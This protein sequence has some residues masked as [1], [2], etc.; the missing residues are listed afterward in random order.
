MQAHTLIRCTDHPGLA[1]ILRNLCWLTDSRTWKNFAGSPFPYDSRQILRLGSSPQHPG[2][3]IFLRS[4]TPVN[5]MGTGNGPSQDIPASN[6]KKPVSSMPKKRHC[7]IALSMADW[8]PWNLRSMT[9]LDYIPFDHRI[10]DQ[11]EEWGVK[12]AEF[13]KLKYGRYPR[14]HIEELQ[15]EDAGHDDDPDQEHLEYEESGVENTD[16]CDSDRLRD[17]V[18]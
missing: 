12:R 15:A 4:Q 18:N 2:A 1:F 5:F 9:W 14:Q 13:M 8:R 3:D 16:G 7:I 6:V 17:K 11:Y 10:I